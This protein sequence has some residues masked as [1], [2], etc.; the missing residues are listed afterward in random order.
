MTNRTLERLEA[1]L[2]FR[3]KKRDL[4]DKY[5]VRTT[6][7]KRIFYYS[8][9]L[10]AAT[11]TFTL[12][13]NAYYYFVLVT[14]SGSWE[15]SEAAFNSVSTVLPVWNGSVVTYLMTYFAKSL[16]ETKW[17]KENELIEKRISNTT[18]YGTENEQ[19]NQTEE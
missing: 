5:K 2:A 8:K 11:L 10:V 15:I 3:K 13:V 16:F 17:E 7:T 14:M 19:E 6:R 1:K 4:V 12:L 18:E 9:K